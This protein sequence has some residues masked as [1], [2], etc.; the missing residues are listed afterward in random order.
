MKAFLERNA[1]TYSFF[2]LAEQFGTGQKVF[3]LCIGNYW[4]WKFSEIEFK[5]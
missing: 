5:K 3:I 4:F 1:P 2:F